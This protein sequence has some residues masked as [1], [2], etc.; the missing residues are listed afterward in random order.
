MEPEGVIYFAY[1]ATNPELEKDDQKWQAIRNIYPDAII[2]NPEKVAGFGFYYEAIKGCHLLIVSEIENT[3]TLDVELEIREAIK[4]NI[5]V[6]AI[7][8]HGEHH[9]FHKIVGV[10]QLDGQ[11]TSWRCAEVVL[12]D[13]IEEGQLEIDRNLLTTLSDLFASP[14]LY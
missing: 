13:P 3:I 14:D 6:F 8:N 11:I 1:C 4:W 2:I 12:K 10:K 9:V 5:P 7:R